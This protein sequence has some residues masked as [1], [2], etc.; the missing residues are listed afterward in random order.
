MLDVHGLQQRSAL[1]QAVRSFFIER[2]CLEVDTPIRLPTLLP[3]ANILPFPSDGWFLQ[4][5]PELCMKRLLARG[6][7]DIFQI[8]HCFR[9]E[10]SG[11]LHQPE[12]TML[13]WYR[14]GWDYTDLM[15]EC[16]ELVNVLAAAVPDLPGVP[17][18]PAIRR[19]GCLVDLAPPWERLTVAEA[20]RRY[21]GVEAR[22]T[23]A[24]GDFI[25]IIFHFCCKFI[26]Y[27]SGKFST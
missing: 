25:K 16:E 9:R 5:S 20:F 8:C 14:T 15:Q 21:A 1:L 22:D 17:P 2:N 10:E 3:E 11:R 7:T 24:A 23:L 26:I 12:F 4:P 19:G 6:C 18:G 13:E 27:D